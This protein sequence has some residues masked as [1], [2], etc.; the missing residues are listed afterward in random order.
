MKASQ[1]F[2]DTPLQ[3][4]KSRTDM[5]E[6][7]RRYFRHV[8]VSLLQPGRRHMQASAH[9]PASAPNLPC[10]RLIPRGLPP[11][12]SSES[13]FLVE[14]PTAVS[15]LME[16]SVRL[17]QWDR[18]SLVK[19]GMWRM[20]RRTVESLMSRPARRKYCIFRSWLRLSQPG[21]TGGKKTCQGQGS[22]KKKGRRRVLYSFLTWRGHQIPDLK[23]FDS[24]CVPQVQRAQE[25]A[26]GGAKSR[27]GRPATASQHQILQPCQ[28][29]DEIC[30]CVTAIFER[31]GSLIYLTSVF[32][33]D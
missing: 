32:R 7:R 11:R 33:T 5:H 31:R 14:E 30:V 18:S 25:R 17:L 6:R 19:W 4:R 1:A 16:W 20:T 10:E 22:K 27:N 23:V 13:V 12:L 8:S 3:P 26:A 21:K 29:Q 24:V 15:R 9:A 2:L 28:I